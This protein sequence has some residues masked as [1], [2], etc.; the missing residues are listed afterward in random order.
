MLNYQ[1][2]L[3][4]ALCHQELKNGKELLEEVEK[5]IEAEKKRLVA[6]NIRDAFGR[7]VHGLELGV[8]TG[9]GSRRLYNVPWPL[10]RSAI[11]AHMANIERRLV[12]L[13]EGARLELSPLSEDA[14][15]REEFAYRNDP[16]RR[17]EQTP[18]EVAYDQYVSTRRD[19]EVIW[20]FED[21]K[22][23]Q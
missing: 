9:R 2:A 16:S 17:S 1:T 5:A 11:I 4:I 12:V 10:A 20:D 3:D 22:A 8:P 21:W 18:E 15:S 23:R 14:R 6:D 19:G 7:P 13:N